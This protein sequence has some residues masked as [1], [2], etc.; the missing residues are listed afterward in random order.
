MAVLTH[1]NPAAVAPRVEQ[2][3]PGSVV[4]ATEL[5]LY[6]APDKLREVARFLH[7]DPELRLDFLSMVTAVDYIDYFEL[8][9]YLISI[10]NNSEF[11]LK[12]RVADR[13][14][15]AVPSLYPIYA[16]ANFQ[17]R[18]VWDMFGI[19]FEGHPNL[20]RI[21]TWEGFEGF[22]LRKDYRLGWRLG[23]WSPDWA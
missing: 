21:L 1:L 22:P 2:A 9:Y 17:E 18:E 7:D 14:A 19:R 12:A 5:A 8:V 15:P 20:K 13:R 10:P 23:R 4:E 6:V 11:Y 16:G 3:V